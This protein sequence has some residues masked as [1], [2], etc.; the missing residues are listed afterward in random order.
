MQPATVGRRVGRRLVFRL[1]DLAVEAAARQFGVE[2]LLPLR[3]LPVVLGE[4]GEAIALTLHGAADWRPL[5][6]LRRIA[7]IEP[8]LANR[9]GDD[10]DH[11]LF[12]ARLALRGAHAATDRR[13]GSLFGSAGGGFSAGAWTTEGRVRSI[14]TAVRVLA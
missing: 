6:I 10:V 1:R 9:K 4:S 3:H 8:A 5:R 14:R 7:G 11:W 2:R 13:D 12:P